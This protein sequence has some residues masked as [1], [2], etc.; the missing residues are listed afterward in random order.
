MSAPVGF[1]LKFVREERHLM[2]PPLTPFRLTQNLYDAL[3]QYILSKDQE[4]KLQKFIDMLEE[5]I[6]LRDQ[7]PFSVPIEELEFL[8]EGLQELRLLNWSEIPVAVFELV[9]P[10]S[11]DADQ[12]ETIEVISDLLM[13]LTIFKRPA[14]SNLI[15]VYPY[16]MVR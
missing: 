15:W 1:D 16:T 5:H 10:E 8:D 7:T 6:K 13:R 4:E 2:L 14:G 12:E 11:G 3:F 9:L